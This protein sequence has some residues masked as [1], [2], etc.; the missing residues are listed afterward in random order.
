ML[1]TIHH[2]PNIK[3]HI[4]FTTVPL[5]EMLPP[6]TPRAP[7]CYAVAAEGP[8]E[9]GRVPTGAEAATPATE[10]GSTARRGLDTE[11]SQKSRWLNSTKT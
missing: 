11:M 6:G 7:P 8:F 1:N 4:G 10:V 9:C 2:H 3:K 5:K